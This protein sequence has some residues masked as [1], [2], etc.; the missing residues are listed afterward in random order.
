MRDTV[1]IMKAA[2]QGVNQAIGQGHLL[3]VP[4]ELKVKSLLEK[5]STKL[6]TWTMQSRT[7]QF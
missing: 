3:E 5:G 4:M 6:T 7:A 1:V 2:D